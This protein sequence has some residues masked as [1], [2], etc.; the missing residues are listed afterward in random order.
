M[1][2]LRRTEGPGHVV[3]EPELGRELRAFVDQRL[4]ATV[5]AVHHVQNRAQVQDPDDVGERPIAAVLGEYL[6]E[7]G[8]RVGQLPAGQR[9]RVVRAGRALPWLGPLPPPLP[10]GPVQRV[11]G[12]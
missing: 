3:V 10:A 9:D 2:T 11:L 8:P 6:P 1:N 7:R 5:A 12:R 4:G